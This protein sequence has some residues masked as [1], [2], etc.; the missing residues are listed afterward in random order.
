M[1]RLQ[2]K[3]STFKGPM[4]VLKQIVRKEG[5][6]GLYSGMEATFWRYLGS[7]VIHSPFLILPFKTRLVEWRLLWVNS[8]SEE[9]DA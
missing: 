7:P 3:T 4:D 1:S 2:D 6:L 9:L 5:L 8:P